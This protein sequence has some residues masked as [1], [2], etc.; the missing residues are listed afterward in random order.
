MCKARLRLTRY[1]SVAL[2]GPVLHAEPASDAF[3]ERLTVLQIQLAKD[4][5]NLVTLFKLGDLCHDEGA[6]DNPK[7]VILAEKYL[8]QVLA[9]NDKHAMALALLGSTYTMKGRD[10]FWPPTRIELVKE[11]N[12]KMD[13]AVRLAPEDPQVRFVR[14]INNF[15]MPKWLGREEIVQADF[16]WLWEKARSKPEAFENDFKQ[17]VALHHGLLLK[18][19]QRLDDAI[20]VWQAGLE[21][22]PDSPLARQIRKELDKARRP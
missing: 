12:R 2:L 7:A 11:G 20:S 17:D 8:E 18:R 3:Q 4:P 14:A 5:T 10:A 16:A 1:L 19:H 21:F 6:K 9:L 22:K 15:H 13:A